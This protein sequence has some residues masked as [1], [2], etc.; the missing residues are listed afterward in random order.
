MGII[1]DIKNAFDGDDSNDP[2]HVTKAKDYANQHDDKIDAGVDRAGEFVDDKTGGK[3][4]DKVD[5]GQDFIKDRTG[6]PDAPAS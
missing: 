5:Q 6:N 4:A 2:D 1:D 3:Y